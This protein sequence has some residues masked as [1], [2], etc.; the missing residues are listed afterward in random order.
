MKPYKIY[1]SFGAVNKVTVDYDNLTCGLWAENMLDAVLKF[2]A[3]HSSE[4]EI[5][6][7]SINKEVYKEEC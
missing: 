3:T 6:S 4:A 2:K 7:I 1:W 5:I